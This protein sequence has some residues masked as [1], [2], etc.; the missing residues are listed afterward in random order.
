MRAHHLS[1]LLLLSACSE[2]SLHSIDPINT[3]GELALS[4]RVCDA[5]TLKIISKPP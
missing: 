1:A 3:V 2:Q 4:G 5:D